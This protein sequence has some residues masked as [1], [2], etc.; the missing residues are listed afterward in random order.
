MGG[1]EFAVGEGI[2]EK[3]NVA[4]PA[5]L[6]PTQPSATVLPANEIRRRMRRG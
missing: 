2:R 3:R 5:A 1:Q 6:S 4:I